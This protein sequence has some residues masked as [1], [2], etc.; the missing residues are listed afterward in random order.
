MRVYLDEKYV[1]RRAAIA[2]WASI[3]GLAVLGGGFAASIVAPQLIVV[4]FGALI[5]GFLLSN[6]GIYYSNRYLRLDRPDVALAQAL[7]GLD[8][9]YALYQFLL[10]VSQ[11]LLEPG[12]LTACVL[13]PQEGQILYQDGKWRNKQ[14]WGRLLRWVGQEGLGKP[15]QEVEMAVEALQKWLA[16]QAP[17]L[18][19]PIR[20]IVV[21]TRSNAELTLDNPPVPTM[22]T[23]QV[24]KW[25][26]KAGKRPE[27]AE[28]TYEQL[29]RL[30]PDTAA[31]VDDASA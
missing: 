18:E 28:E 9:R 4:S 8:N 16:S 19:V 12:G 25:L 24:K 23:S 22:T 15:Q 13:K 6:V 17:D 1:K 10:P 21:F 26:R 3:L 30:L 31:P 14:G 2:K 27:L 29:S 20:G 11:V 7:K 5:L